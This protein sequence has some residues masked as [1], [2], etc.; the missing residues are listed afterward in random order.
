[1]QEG[2]EAVLDK[3]SQEEQEQLQIH[4]VKCISGKRRAVNWSM[5]NSI[6]ASHGLTL[7]DKDEGQFEYL[8]EWDVKG[9]KNTWEPV[10]NLLNVKEMIREYEQEREEKRQAKSEINKRIEAMRKRSRKAIHKGSFEKNN[11]IKAVVGLRRNKFDNQLMCKVSWHPEVIDVADSVQATAANVSASGIV[12]N[13]E[14]S[15]RLRF[16]QPKDSF[17]PLYY[18]KQRYPEYIVE[19]FERQI[20][21]THYRSLTSFKRD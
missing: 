12:Y 14:P 11:R 9:M 10:E 3:N 13:S 16:F 5:N 7:A 18:M 6:E 4:P 1:M 15:E 2:A 20:G 17:V 21:L 8:V 19:Y